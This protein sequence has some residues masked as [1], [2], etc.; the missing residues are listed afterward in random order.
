[1]NKL[2]REKERARQRENRIWDGHTATMT[3]TQNKAAASVTIEDYVEYEKQI[4][5]KDVIGPQ[6]RPT[7][8]Q[9]L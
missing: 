1:M 5:A 3:S 4:K 8:R 2:E 6:A 9:K 7:K